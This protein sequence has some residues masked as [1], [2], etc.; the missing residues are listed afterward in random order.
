MRRC[1]TPIGSTTA[2]WLAAANRLYSSSATTLQSQPSSQDDPDSSKIVALLSQWKPSTAPLHRTQ[3]V[4]DP[5]LLAESVPSTTEQTRQTSNVS[6]QP[7]QQEPLAA[8]DERDPSPLAPRIEPTVTIGKDASH[9]PRP[10]A[11]QRRPLPI[12]PLMDPAAIAAKQKHHAPKA[13]PSKNPE[14][15][16][17]ILAKNPYALA[18][19]TPLRRCQLTYV[20]LPSFFLQDFNLMAH[21]ETGDPWYVPRSLTNKHMP[22]PPR[23]PTDLDLGAEM[24]LDLE[25]KDE[26]QLDGQAEKIGREPGPDIGFTVYTLSSQ[27]AIRALMEKDGYATK[28]R[29]RR[30]LRQAKHMGIPQSAHVQLVP[31]RY[32]RA[33]IASKVVSKAAWRTDMHE[34]VLELLR[35]RTVEDLVRVI[36][37]KRGY[38]V[39]CSGWDDAKAKPQVGAF[40]WTGGN[41]DMEMDVPHEFATLDVSTQV[42]KTRKVPVHNLRA[43]LG[44]EKLAELREKLP[45][46]IFQKEVLILRHKRVTV[47]L[48]M[49]LWKLQG[50]L[51]EYRNL[52]S[53]GEKQDAVGDWED[54]DLE[55]SES[56][57][58]DEDE[59]EM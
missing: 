44:R 8:N 16:Q 46:G 40:L 2:R 24:E 18:L 23:K 32:R 7:I 27:L 35:R 47:E 30:A 11:Y 52:F 6:W 28:S 21:P 9:T 53:A 48:E 25:S 54:D 42:D 38:I 31:D 34:F 1:I 14:P 26:T 45:S 3:D 41:G 36:R 20:G 33:K 57:E 39:G 49:R 50:Y 13:P 12:S 5:S 4:Q 19:A 10:A 37:L 58:M 29:P 15:F 59:D 55:D 43:L 22:A 51:A 56:D 17:Q